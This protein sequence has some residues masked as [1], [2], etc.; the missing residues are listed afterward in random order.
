VDKAGGAVP[1]PT[2][3]LTLLNPRFAV[4]LEPF[5][6][7]VA[8][9][10]AG[11]L[12]LEQSAQFERGSAD[13]ETDAIKALQ[14]GRT[15]LAVVPARAFGLVGVRSFDALIA[16]MEVD[17]M[18]LQQ[19]VLSSGIAT[20]MV[21]GVESVGLKGVG[22]LPGPMRLAAGITRPLRTPQDFNGA[23]IAYSP[24]AVAERSLRTLH[25][26]PVKSG[27]EGADMSAFDG[28]ESQ[29]QSIAGNRYDDDVR[30]ITGNVQLWPRAL[31]VVANADSFA[32]LTDAQRAW[33]TKAIHNAI[34]PTTALQTNNEEL[35]VLCRR[36]KAQTIQA[37]PAQVK[38]LRD[39]FA[40][41]YEWLRG[42]PS[43]AR[44]LDQIDALKPQVTA[45]PDEVV[46]C[47]RL[48][49]S[50]AGTP[51]ASPSAAAPGAVSPIDGNYLAKITKSDL[52]KANTPPGDIVI[53]NYGEFRFVFERGRFA[54]TQHES[55]ACTWGFG[56]FTVTDDKLQMSFID[57]GG[58]SP[59]GA[60]NQPGELFDYAWSTYKGAMKWSAVPGA[61]SPE[62]WTSKPWLRQDEA[63]TSKFLA[64]E[65]PP[66]ASA[67]ER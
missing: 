35:G 29:I 3:T 58:K 34:P 45:D 31:V 17:S 52:Q 48:S 1:E 26:T 63:P 64:K 67:F 2:R 41:V 42:D 24:S 23:R 39:G 11:A 57:G 4:E 20:E 53:E 62:P 25:A 46:D 50:P 6:D 21:S 65:C 22:I 27:F 56:T 54:Y 61:I 5:V 30:W 28:L 32:S 44:Y 40:P 37:S 51:S 43:T 14:D 55:P 12:V 13:S 33:L 49:Q 9:L 36:G 15:D 10:S 60:Y 59:H 18:S 47:S 7:E 66:P 38:Q 8:K 19:Q 16:P